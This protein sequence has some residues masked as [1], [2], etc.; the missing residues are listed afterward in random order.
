MYGYLV[1]DALIAVVLFW[2]CWR[3]R[4]NP[5]VAALCAPVG[6]FFAVMALVAPHVALANAGATQP[7]MIAA[8]LLAIAGTIITFIEV[9]LGKR[10]HPVRTPVIG[11][12]YGMAVATVYTDKA[13]MSQQA[14]LFLP[15][16]GA[17][18]AQSAA[19]A[20]P[21]HV[22]STSALSQYLP[23][24]AILALVTGAIF[25]WLR[26]QH[27]RR[28]QP[29]VKPMTAHRRV[30]NA[31]RKAKGIGGGRKGRGGQFGSPEEVL[32]GWQP[33]GAPPMGGGPRPAINSP[34]GRRG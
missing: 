6:T 21:T 29:H 28:Q 18:L 32:G 31:G 15:N 30:I 2:L 3:F 25:M 4:G 20:A 27:A 9:I 16:S 26:R 14:K 5:R 24:L 23:T 34:R 22:V 11:V 1:V 12:I 17:Q 8:I 19:S 13:L 10:H 7:G 33:D